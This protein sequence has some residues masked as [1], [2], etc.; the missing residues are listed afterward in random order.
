M[1]QA[2]T[3][4]GDRISRPVGLLLIGEAIACVFFAIAHLSLRIPLGFATLHEPR[5]IPATIVEMLCGIIL[6]IGGVAL[7]THHPRAWRTAIAAQTFTLCGFLLGIA[8]N[9][10]GGNDDPV[11]DVF[12]GVMLVLLILGLLGSIV[13]HR[14]GQADAPVIEDRGVA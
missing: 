1:A 3:Q 11:N 7:L 14:R 10:G 12:H 2:S 13:M 4:D 5:V 9:A 6:L 8:A